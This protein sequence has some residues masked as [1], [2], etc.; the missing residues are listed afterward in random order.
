[1]IEK[2]LKYFISTFL[3]I[4]F[5]IISLSISVY[6]SDLIMTN[7]TISL[8]NAP[9]N[10]SLIVAAYD[11]NN[12]L[13]GCE[14]YESENTITGN[15]AEDMREEMSR[16]HSIK[17]FIWDTKTLT[18]IS[19][20][21][22]NDVLIVY[23]SR[24]NTTEALANNIHA[25]IGG[26][27]IE[28]YP[29]EP[30]SD[31][32]QECSER[33]QEEIAL[34]AR[35]EILT[36]INNIDQYDTILVGYPIWRNTVPPVVRTFLDSYD[37]TGKTIMPF[38]THGGSGISGSMAKIRELCSGS[39]ITSG[40]DSSTETSIDNWLKENGFDQG[41]NP[42][43]PDESNILVA[44]FSC[45]N[46]TEGIAEY[47]IDE[48][49]ADRYEII[50]AVPYTAEDLNYS[51]SDCRAN[52]EQNDPSARPQISGYVENIESYDIVFLGYPIWR[53]QAPKIIYTFLE[54]YDLS[55]KIIV[56]F[57]T[58]ASS[59]IGSSASNLHDICSDSVTWLSGRRFAASATRDSVI[60]WINDLE[61]NNI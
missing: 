57:C 26:D 33:A 51:N 22:N 47:I 7:G 17:A 45:A 52:R 6:A 9:D 12:M 49:N 27:L 58:S 19:D 38:C 28:I 14:I 43:E 35:P 54:S 40:L 56:P 16:A 46:N 37:L 41:S 13:L 5:N 34:D 44:Y 10:K 15:Y 50:P 25:K 3:I 36:R 1:M 30:Y 48:L 21:N 60:S 29:V 53:G 18:P 2:T 23:F 61:L 39:N 42:A 31:I 32:Y 20:E 59:N 11:E 24:T 55:G 8:E 4:I